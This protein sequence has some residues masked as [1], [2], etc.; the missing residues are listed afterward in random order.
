LPRQAVILNTEQINFTVLAADDFGVKRIGMS[1]KG[2]EDDL[3]GQPAN[4]ERLLAPGGPDQ[5]AVQTPAVFSAS[6]LGIEPQ[7][8]EVR[9]WVEDY[10]PDRPRVESAPHVFFVLSP[11]QHAIW[12]TEQLSKWHRLA[13]DVRDRE[14]R[15]H[16]TNKQLRDMSPQELAAQEAAKRLQEQATA[17]AS[18][19]RQLAN[20]SRVGEDLIRQASRNSEIGV[21]HL[22]RWAEMLQI[23]KDISAN[24][25]PSVADLL[26]QAAAQKQLAAN[27]SS[28]TGPRTKSCV[29]GGKTR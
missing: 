14:M 13:L 12:M 3:V 23:L 24:R 26:K 5:N 10:L 17:E 8:I 6:A 15:L 18:N 22:E 4:G 7:A 25:M 2:V 9:L 1:W 19:G 11:E 21:G 28:P 20:L 27:K 16:E 29:R